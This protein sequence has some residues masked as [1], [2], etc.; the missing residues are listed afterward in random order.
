MIAKRL[1][2][3]AEE[4]AMRYA[5][6]CQ[7]WQG[8]FD[9]AL[10]DKHFGFA[11][12]PSNVARE[13]YALAETYLADERD[14]I[15][16]I[17]EEVAREAHQT[18]LSQIASAD[19]DELED[20]ALDHLA[21][22]AHYLADE[23]IAQIH[24]DIAMVRQA[25][26][27]IQLEVYTAARARRIPERQA[28]IEHQIAHREALQFMFADRYARKWSS[29]KFVRGLWRHTLLSAYNET[30]MIDLADHG[31]ETAAVMHEQDGHA[32]TISLTGALNLMSYADSRAEYFHPNSNAYLSME[33]R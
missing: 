20:A 3:L 27:R 33:P 29:K 19:S 7:L 30:V 25:V 21:Q 1:T 4:S 2:Q 22:T 12:H 15:D 17:I 10:T 28:L 13:C 31:L 9:R 32:A 18:T 11:D 16:R 26:Q 23:L 24:R 8:V 14:H 6:L 5:A